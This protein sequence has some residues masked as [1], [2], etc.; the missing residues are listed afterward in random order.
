MKYITI[1]QTAQPETASSFQVL[2]L[3]FLHQIK[4]RNILVNFN[5]KHVLYLLMIDKL[6]KS[7]KICYVKYTHCT[8]IFIIFLVN[9]KSMG[10]LRFGI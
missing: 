5:T 6:Y 7:D 9:Y 2:Y 3:W 4:N 1:S 8:K 10:F